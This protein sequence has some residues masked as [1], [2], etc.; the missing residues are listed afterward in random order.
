MRNFSVGFSE[1]ESRVSW[2]TPPLTIGSVEKDARVSRLSASSR[3]MG[4]VWGRFSVPAWKAS[5]RI[6]AECGSVA[7]PGCSSWKNAALFSRNGRCFGNSRIATSSLG[8]HSE[9]DS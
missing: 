2:F 8:G 4:G 6:G 1:D 9:I 5:A 3:L 7:T